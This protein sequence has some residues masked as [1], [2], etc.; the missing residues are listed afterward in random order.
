[1]CVCVRVCAGCLAEICQMGI[2]TKKAKAAA[3]ST[4]GTEVVLFLL[5]LLF[6]SLQRGPPNFEVPITPSTHIEL[7]QSKYLHA[8]HLD[9]TLHP[10]KRENCLYTLSK[11]NDIPLF[12]VLPWHAFHRLLSWKRVFGSA[13][14]GKPFILCHRLSETKHSQTGLLVA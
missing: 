7:L 8:F 4:G 10:V 3:A 12:V 6:P 9:D 5:K 14:L 11:Y 2:F 1:M 13:P